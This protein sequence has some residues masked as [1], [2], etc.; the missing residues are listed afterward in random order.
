MWAERLYA[1]VD[2]R[3]LSSSCK[4]AGQL[5]WGFKVTEE[6]VYPLPAGTLKPDLVAFK[7]NS[8]LVLDAQVVGDS[9]ELDSAYTAK[10]VKYVQLEQAVKVQTGAKK[11]E[12]SSITLNSRG[13]WSPAS[14]EKLLRLGVK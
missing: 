10:I 3:A 9:V 4:T 11:V 6:P 2:G 7:N 5:T 14:A 1:S 8:A 12:F 13:V